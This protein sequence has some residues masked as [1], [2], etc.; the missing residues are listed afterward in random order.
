MLDLS[1]LHSD[2]R[3]HHQDYHHA[4]NDHN[5]HDYDHQ[6]HDNNIENVQ[7]VWDSLEETAAV[8]TPCL[9]AQTLSGDLILKF[10]CLNF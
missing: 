10:K 6:H 1:D 9:A 5:D 7:A 2:Y 8:P 4:H 3:H